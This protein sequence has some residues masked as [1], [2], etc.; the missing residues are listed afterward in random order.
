MEPFRDGERAI[1]TR[2]LPLSPSAAAAKEKKADSQSR[3][4]S[5]VE[6]RSEKSIAM[7]TGF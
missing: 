6:G 1:K 2:A 4:H 7:Q 3:R 5:F